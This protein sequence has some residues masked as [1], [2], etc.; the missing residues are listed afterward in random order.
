MPAEAGI[1]GAFAL[2]LQPAALV[3]YASV[4]NKPTTEVG[5]PNLA[6][7]SPL[8]KPYRTGSNPGSGYCGKLWNGKKT[9][10]RNRE[11]Q[12]FAWT[13]WRAH[14]ETGAFNSQHQ[15]ARNRTCQPVS[16]QPLSACRPYDPN[17]RNFLA[18]DNVWTAS[19]VLTL[20]TVEE[21]GCGSSCRIFC[22]SAFN[23]GSS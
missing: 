8:K 14:E 10:R 21:S 15:P 23:G 16:W 11:E 1:P 17:M 18:L 6:L 13:D 3:L 5:A 2:K 12:D 9:W 19:P 7:V 4:W 20:P 22:N